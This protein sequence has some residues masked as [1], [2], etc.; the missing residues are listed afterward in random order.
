MPLAPIKNEKEYNSIENDLKKWYERTGDQDML[1]ET[2]KLFTLLIKG[3]E[4]ATNSLEN[5]IE[6]SQDVTRNALVPFS[7]ELRRRNDIIGDYQNLPLYVKELMYFKEPY[8]INL[9]KGLNTPD[10]ENP[11]LIALDP[12]QIVYERGE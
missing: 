6:V 10:V 12:P 7:T 11:K 4:L 1:R 2:E 8:T 9:N 5:K 3:Q